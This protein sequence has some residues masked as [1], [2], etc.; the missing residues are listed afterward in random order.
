[1]RSIKQQATAF[2]ERFRFSWWHAK[3]NTGQV[4]IYSSCFS[5]PLAPHRHQHIVWDSVA[6]GARRLLIVTLF[7]IGS[8]LTR[9]LLKK[10]GFRPMILGVSLWVLVS[11][12]T[13]TIIS[14]G[15]IHWTQSPCSPSFIINTG[16]LLQRLLNI[17]HRRMPTWRLQND[18]SGGIKPAMEYFNCWV[19]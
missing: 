16:P 14:R 7:L 11:A 12:A 2:S 15:I 6:F 4:A 19:L 8:W 9:E 10:V 5:M 13:L 17:F 3:N 1:M 18:T